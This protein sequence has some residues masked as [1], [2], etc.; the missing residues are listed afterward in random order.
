MPRLSEGLPIQRMIHQP[1]SHKSGVVAGGVTRDVE[2][3]EQTVPPQR[4]WVVILQEL[5]GTHTS[6]ERVNATVPAAKMLKAS[7]LTNAS[8]IRVA[9]LA[10]GYGPALKVCALGPR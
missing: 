7:S 6:R 9:K 3:L 10:E 4:D 8:V 1:L 5:E 2:A